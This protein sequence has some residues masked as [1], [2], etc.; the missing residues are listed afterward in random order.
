ML[1]ITLPERT[2]TSALTRTVINEPG[3]SVLQAMLSLA[4]P[5]PP[6]L[7]TARVLYGAGLLTVPSKLA[8]GRWLGPAA[9][10]PA[11]TVALRGMGARETLLHVG[12]LAATL[13]GKP[14]RPW[15]ASIA[16]DLVDIAATTAAR[17]RLPDGS[18]VATA[19][20]AGGSAVLSGIAAAFVDA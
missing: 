18:A 3:P 8:A 1:D 9:N 4:P 5:A 20:V 6:P 2:L 11:A 19:A 15:L 17:H 7:L 14:V 16:G 10:E 12:A 13:T